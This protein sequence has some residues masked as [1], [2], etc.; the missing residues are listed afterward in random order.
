MRRLTIVGDGSTSNQM[1]GFLNA[2]GIPA[3]GANGDEWLD[4][5][6]WPAAGDPAVD[7]HTHYWYSALF[8]TENHGNI[9]TRMEE[10]NNQ[11]GTIYWLFE[12]DRTGSSILAEHDWQAL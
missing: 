9:I 7:P 4:V 1:K 8:S 2:E 6:L 11:P 3:R 12:D 5:F 10:V